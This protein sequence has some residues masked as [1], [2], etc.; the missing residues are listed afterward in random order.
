MLKKKIKKKNPKDS[1][2]PTCFVFPFVQQIE[3]GHLL[4]TVQIRPTETRAQGKGYEKGNGHN[5]KYFQNSP[6]KH[7]FIQK[8]TTTLQ[9][10]N[11][12]KL[13]DSSWKLIILS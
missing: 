10:P 6:S 11:A 8:T 13:S 1:Q 5:S 7:N 3:I 2:A 12:F 9:P 4:S